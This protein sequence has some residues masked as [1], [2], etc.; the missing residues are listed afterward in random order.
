MRGTAL[1]K[2]QWIVFIE[3]IW[4]GDIDRD[5]GKAFNL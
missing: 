1:L 5:Q 4:A 3:R 2:F